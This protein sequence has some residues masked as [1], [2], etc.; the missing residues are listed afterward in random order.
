MASATN[1]AFEKLR[2]ER[3]NSDLSISV[4]HI[5]VGGNI[6]VGNRN[7]IGDNSIICEVNNSNG[8]VINL[9]APLSIKPIGI[10]QQPPCTPTR[11][12]GR[13]HE[14]KG[15][16]QS[17]RDKRAILIYG[18]HG[19]GNKSVAILDALSGLLIIP[20]GHTNGMFI[21]FAKFVKNMV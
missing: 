6:V 15:L 19:N 8:V 20:N 10:K 3:A 16:E 5:N 4:G 11:F 9:Q 17:I 2:S 12:V 14:L 1:P 7:V 21:V 13:E 18:E